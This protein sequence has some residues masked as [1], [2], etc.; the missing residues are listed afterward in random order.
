MQAMA[1]RKLINELRQSHEA[2]KL[3][4]RAANEIE[5]LEAE[6]QKAVNERNAAW[7]KLEKL[8]QTA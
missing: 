3:T 4:N 8:G 6:L 1:D 5:M 2:S 7:F